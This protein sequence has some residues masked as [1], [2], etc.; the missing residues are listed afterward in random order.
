MHYSL[1]KKWGKQ[2][3]RHAGGGQQ[4]TAEA[5]GPAICLRRTSVDRLRA[6]DARSKAA[7]GEAGCPAKLSVGLGL[8]IDGLESHPW[9]WLVSCPAN[10]LD[11]S[12]EHPQPKNRLQSYARLCARVGH[13]ERISGT[14]H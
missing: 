8:D 10:S 11:K 3:G 9:L 13:I 7:A 12:L 6:G 14:R 5:A 1:C 4:P 2:E